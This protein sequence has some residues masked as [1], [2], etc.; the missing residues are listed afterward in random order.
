MPDRIEFEASS[1]GYSFHR[2]AEILPNFPQKEMKPTAKEF[3]KRIKPLNARYIL[4]RAYNF[5]KIPSWHPGAGGDPWIF[6]DEI[7]IR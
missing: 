1:N 6:V 7:L 5:G 2:I 4:V 3:T